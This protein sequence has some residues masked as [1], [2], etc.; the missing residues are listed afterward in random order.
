[1][2]DSKF[3]IFLKKIEEFFNMNLSQHKPISK[4]LKKGEAVFLKSPEMM[5]K[6]ILVNVSDLF[7]RYNY[8]QSAYLA[9]GFLEAGEPAHYIIGIDIKGIEI[10]QLMERMAKELH[11]LIP[12]DFYVDFVELN[13]DKVGMDNSV[14]N[15]MKN[16]LIPFYTR[17]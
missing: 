16:C 5:P 1:M 17:Q 2:T 15:F 14:E 13:A 6:E 3:Y 12:K 8:I 4:V 9:E 7:K 11:E 10:G